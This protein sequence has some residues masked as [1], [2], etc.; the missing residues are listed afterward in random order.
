MER[1]T[2]QVVLPGLGRQGQERLAAAHVAVVG[3]GALGSVGSELL[4]RAGVGRLT[5]IDRDILEWHNLHR[6]S[7]YTEAD[8]VARLPKAEAARRHLTAINAEA[9]VT[10]RIAD[11]D[12]A[13]APMLL[14]G[15]DAILDGTDNF[16][17]RYLIND[18]SVREGIPWVYGGV[19]GTDGVSMTIRPGRTPCLRCLFPDPPPAGSLPTCETAGVWGPT[20][21]LVASVEASAVL[22][23]LIGHDPPEGMVHL[24][25]WGGHLLRLQGGGR[26]PACPACGGG[27][28]DFLESGATGFSVRPCGGGSVHVRPPPGAEGRGPEQPRMDLAALAAALEPLVGPVRANS[29]LIQFKA[30]ECEITLFADGRALVK[31]TGDPARAR[32]LYARFVGT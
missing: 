14:E 21:H 4:I 11:L 18:L 10:A 25:L 8:V 13:T 29:F 15:A 30:E 24:D 2:R 17:T 22:Q 16:E 5:V 19:L 6:Q 1:Y 27:R 20:V 31:G 12:A 23:L 32:T 28:Y 9:E 26:D 3:M 7:L